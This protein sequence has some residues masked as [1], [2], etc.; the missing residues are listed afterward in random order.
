MASGFDQPNLFEDQEYKYGSFGNPA[1]AIRKRARE[2][3]L[4]GIEIARRFRSRDISLE[5]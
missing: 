2:N 4:E 1:P 3:T 5:V